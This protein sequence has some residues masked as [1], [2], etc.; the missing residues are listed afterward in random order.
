MSALKST[1]DLLESAEGLPTISR[2]VVE[3]IRC[4]DDEHSRLED[5]V[6]PISS[7]IGLT[8]SI[9]RIANS[10]RFSVHGNI[11]SINDAIMVIGLRQ[12]RTIVCLI[13]IR[14]SF[15][16]NR[17]HSFDYANFWLHSTGVAVCAKRL[18]RLAGVNSNVGFVSGMLHDVGHLV[19]A[20]AA[21]DDFGKVMKY[22]AS[23]NCQDYEAEQAVLGMDH[24]RIGARLAA[25]WGLPQVIC[26]AIEKHHMPDVAPTSLMGDL[27]HV[28]DALSQA[29]EMGYTGHPLPPLSGQAMARLGISFS[30]LKPCLAEIECEYRSAIHL[31]N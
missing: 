3:V 1:D 2:A 28:S 19:L 24:C 25:K 11:A 26:D 18:A 17:L 15:P 4:I 31:L 30:R 5:L 7:D 21:P 22:R 8:T 16:Q 13:G 29:L 6:K 14:E 23:R 12:I 20:V 10:A 9:L 27:I